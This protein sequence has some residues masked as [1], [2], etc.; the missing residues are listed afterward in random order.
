MKPYNL[1]Y[2]NVMS[3]GVLCYKSHFLLYSVDGALMAV[4]SLCSRLMT[5]YSLWRLQGS[6]GRVTCVGLVTDLFVN[7]YDFY[8]E[9]EEGGTK[10]LTN[11]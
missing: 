7:S 1:P 2:T 5:L 9:E 3:H 6:A 8:F 4:A 11:S 10:R